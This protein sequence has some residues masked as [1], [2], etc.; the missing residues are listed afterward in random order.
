MAKLRKQILAWT[1]EHS[2]CSI[3][4]SVYI[5]C[6]EWWSGYL[7]SIKIYL[8]LLEWKYPETNEWNVAK[9]CHLPFDPYVSGKLPACHFCSHL[10]FIM[11]YKISIQEI[12]IILFRDMGYILR[13]NCTAI[14]AF[15]ILIENGAPRVRNNPPQPPLKSKS[16]SSILLIILV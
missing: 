5:L 4:V 11:I 12:F 13:T 15:A 16:T 7:I 2:I 9:L 8:D 3:F 6:P 10:S 14:F 1:T